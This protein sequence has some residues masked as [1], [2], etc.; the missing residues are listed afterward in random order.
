MAYIVRAINPDGVTG[1]FTIE[2][3][4]LRKAKESAQSL[5]ELSWLW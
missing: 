3:N 4:T 1:T 5:R 2:R